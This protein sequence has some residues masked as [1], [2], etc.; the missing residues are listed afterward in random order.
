MLGGSLDD[1]PYTLLEVV[2]DV[3]FEILQGITWEF[4]LSL[5]TGLST[6]WPTGRDA[7]SQA[8]R[9]MAFK[10]LSPIWREV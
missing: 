10:A 4:R 3:R 5:L 1:T 8:V 2:A 9:P 7:F 6:S